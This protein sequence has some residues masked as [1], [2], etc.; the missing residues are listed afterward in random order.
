MKRKMKTWHWI[1]IITVL[2]PVLLITG[3]GIWWACADVESFAEGWALI[4]NIANPPEN[5]IH[6][7]ASYTVSDAKAQKWANKVVAKVAD[8]ELTNGQLQIYYWMEVYTFLNYNSYYAVTAGLDYTLPLDQQTCADY[9]CTWQQYFLERALDSWHE[10][11]AL[12][13]TAE[14]N[15]LTLPA[16]AQANLD[17][18]RKELALSVIE[19]GYPSI[20]AMLQHDMGAGCTFDDYYSYRYTY[21]VANLW[22]TQKSE[23]YLASLSASAIEDYFNLHKTEFAGK[24]ISKDSGLLYSVRHILFTPPGGAMDKDG[25]MTYTEDEYERCREE[26]QALLDKWLAEG[27]TEELFAQY[28][29]DNSADTGSNTNGGLYEGLA[30]DTNILKEFVAWYSDPERKVGDY[31]LVKT[32]QGYHIMYLSTME[33]EWEAASREGLLN[34]ASTLMVDTA[35]ATYPMEVTYKNI[36]LSV[37]DLTSVE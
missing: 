12:A 1:L 16:E 19:G 18:L 3:I 29:N 36:V 30:A 31:G 6:Y 25:N 20:D 24:G 26:A 10:E 23:E 11:Q 9:D 14:A 33:P 13:L 37:V 27:A 5:D 8:R 17:N 7:K 15:G 34:E 28:A 35:K 4:A 32:S 2:V 22:F 21:T